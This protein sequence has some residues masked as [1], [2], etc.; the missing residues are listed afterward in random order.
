M[1][2]FFTFFIVCFDMQKVFFFFYLEEF[3]LTYVSLVAY[4]IGVI[5]KKRKILP[6]TILKTLCLTFL[7]FLSY[8]KHIDRRVLTHTHALAITLPNHSNLLY[9]ALLPC[10]M[11]PSSFKVPQVAIFK[12]PDIAYFRKLAPTFLPLPSSVA[13]YPPLSSYN[14]HT[15]NNDAIF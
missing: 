6:N 10:K 8:P 5:S 4:I 2:H 11:F 1:D 12:N 14:L 9:P 15:C 7:Y 3:Q 13:L